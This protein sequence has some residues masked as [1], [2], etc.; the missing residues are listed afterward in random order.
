M[1]L[2]LLREESIFYEQRIH[3]TICGFRGIYGIS[4]G[5]TATQNDID[6]MKRLIRE[7]LRDIHGYKGDIC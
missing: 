6:T 3:Q 1:N 4:N 5:I 7:I 2:A